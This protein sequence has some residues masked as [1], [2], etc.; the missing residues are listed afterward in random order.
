MAEIPLGRIVG[1]TNPVIGTP[2]KRAVF[3]ETGPLLD[4]TEWTSNYS[5]NDA[6]WLFLRDPAVGFFKHDD[7]K[8]L[9]Y[10]MAYLKKSKAMFSIQ[11][12]CQFL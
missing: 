4:P 5:A 9:V 11:N 8:Y 3:S 12:C 1:V 10:G 2:V 6:D 7:G